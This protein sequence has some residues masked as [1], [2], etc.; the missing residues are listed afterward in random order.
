M[1][2]LRRKLSAMA[3]LFVGMFLASKRRKKPS[4][5]QLGRM[6]FRSSTQKMGLYFPEALRDRFR[7]RWLKLK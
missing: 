3:T 5:Q 6:E 4:P 1:P 2:G 7:N